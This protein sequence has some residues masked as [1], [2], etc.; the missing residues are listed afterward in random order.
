MKREFSKNKVVNCHKG[1]QFAFELGKARIWGSRA[2]DLSNLSDW[3]L[4]IPLL[5]LEYDTYMPKNPLRP[6]QEAID[7][8]PSH[9]AKSFVPAILAIDWPDMEVPYLSRDWWVDLVEFLQNFEGNVVFFCMGGHGRTGTALTIVAT[10]GELI[11]DV[12]CPLYW[13]REQYCTEALE[14]Y[15]QFDY[16][17]QIT[18]TQL[19]T[20]PSFE[21]WYAA[22]P[23]GAT[24][25]Y[26]AKTQKKGKKKKQTLLHQ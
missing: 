13:L 26:P 7:L 3:D 1:P 6:N 5:D 15:R 21:S 18:K 4:M 20:E 2:V 11:P 8:F 14:T 9:I 25:S 22:A 17:E 12:E 16:V 19:W 23:S 10:L 24:V